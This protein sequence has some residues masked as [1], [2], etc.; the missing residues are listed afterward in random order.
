MSTSAARPRHGGAG[1]I[2]VLASRTL[3]RDDG[4]VVLG[5]ADDVRVLTTVGD[6]DRLLPAARR[7]SGGETVHGDGVVAVPLHGDDGRPVGAVCL[8]GAGSGDDDLPVAEALVGFAAVLSDQLDLLRQLGPPPEPAAVRRLE[9]AIDSGRVRAWFQPIVALDGEGLA[10]FEALARW[11]DDAGEVARPGEFVPL[12]EQADLVGRLD[13]AV[14]RDAVGHLAT[15]HRAEPTLRLSVNVSGRHLDEPG[16]LDGIDAVVR[17]AG[18]DPRT[19]DLELTETVRP[20]DVLRSAAELHRARALGYAVWLDDFGT[21][22]SELRHLVELPVDGVKVDRFF[23]EALGGRGDAV[24]RA[25]V[26]IAEELGLDTVVEG[27]SS[28]EHARRA[29]ELGCRLAQGFL[30]SPAVPPDRAGRLV[31]GGGALSRAG[32]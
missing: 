27:V 10:G 23:T 18:V 25:V 8:G 16:W 6:A 11:H 5:D 20:A 1:R 32:R 15:W 22:W 3:R 19:I 7:A 13:Q 2:L 29:H 17:A 12:A 30:W 21:G 14:L 24:V 28:P 31:A 26:A 9:E 4:L